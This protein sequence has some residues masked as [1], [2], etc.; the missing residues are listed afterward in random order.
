M[1]RDLIQPLADLPLKL[2]AAAHPINGVSPEISTHVAFT[3]MDAL[4]TE[5]SAIE[6]RLSG[7]F[8]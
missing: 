5:M 8:R 1:T 6:S 4:T 7:R 3:G 2:R